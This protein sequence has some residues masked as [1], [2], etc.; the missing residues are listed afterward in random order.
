MANM[1]GA[2]TVAVSPLTDSAPRQSVTLSTEALPP[3]EQRVEVSFRYRVLFTEHVFAV[4]N[5][6]LMET[7][8]SSEAATP[9]RFLCVIE[10]GVVRHRPGL[11]AAIQAYARRYSEY[12]SLVEPP[13]VIPG[14]EQVKNM[15]SVISDIHAAID[16]GGI[17]RHS[18][19]LA[20]G[21]GALLDAVGFAAATAHRGVRL[22]RLPTTVLAQCDS[23][24]GVKNGTNAFGKK[25]FIGAFAPPAAVIND[26]AF[27][28]TLP[29]REWRSGLAEAI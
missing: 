23:G 19:V 9:T 18:Y 10:E 21:G 16:R 14:G 24:V 1:W 11:L 28:E 26:A 5:P 3:I 22:V 7:I 25:N 12:I 6:L 2:S 27:L 4:D 20:I 8:A 13:R 17:C 15:P 29:N